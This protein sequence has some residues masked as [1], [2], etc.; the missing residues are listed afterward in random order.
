MP[1]EPEDWPVRNEAGEIV[2]GDAR[3]YLAQWANDRAAESE[4]FR[5]A[6]EKLVAKGCYRLKLAWLLSALANAKRWQ[7]IGRKRLQRIA[8]DLEQAASGVRELFSASSISYWISTLYAS[9]V[10]C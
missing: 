4:D 2:N 6:L 1:D 9:K 10:N 3:T 8:A 5:I 7:G